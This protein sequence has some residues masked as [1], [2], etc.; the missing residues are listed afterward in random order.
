MYGFL[1][2]LNV[3]SIDKLAL[4]LNKVW[5]GHYR[6]L[7]REARFDRFQ[8]V[9][10]VS[11]VDGRNFVEDGKVVVKVK[12]EGIKNIRVG[13]PAVCVL[14]GGG[15]KKGGL[16]AV[17]KV[18]EEKEGG[19]G[20]VQSENKVAD[21]VIAQGSGV[22]KAVAPPCVQKLRGHNKQQSS[23]SFIPRYTSKSYDRMWATSG[24]ISTVI[25]ED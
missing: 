5:I 8:T 13:D 16:E 15:V 18:G 3:R 24:M 14:G 2:F 10:S 22:A 11:S 1:R 25:V 21:S 9:T 20:Q 7:A 12:E 19:A 23:G 17:D 4:A 6:I